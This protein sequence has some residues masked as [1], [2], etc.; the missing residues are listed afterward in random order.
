MFE[1]LKNVIRRG[2]FELTSMLTKI[3][4]L[5]SEDKLTDEQRAELTDSARN[6]A[7]TKN[8]VDIVSK[9][10]DLEARIRA[11]EGGS[12]SSEEYPEFVPGK[13]YYTGDTCTFNGVK[14]SCVAPAGTVCVW[15]PD[16]YPTYWEEA[17]DA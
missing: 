10:T 8:S 6:G 9:L 15:S 2:G 7:D 14:Y 11:L 5:W 16:D 1:I 3:D 4:T 13:W 17:K 12:T